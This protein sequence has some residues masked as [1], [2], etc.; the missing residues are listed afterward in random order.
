M[1]NKLI[2]LC[3]LSSVA[4]SFAGWCDDAAGPNSRGAE[5][6]PSWHVTALPDEGVGLPYDAN[7]CIYWKGAYHLMYIFQDKEGKHCWGHLSSTDLVNW[8][9]HPTALQPNPGDADTGTFSGNAFLD[10]E[11]VPML[12]W[13]GIDAGVC[14]AT[15]QD[16]AL[17]RW[18]K[19]PNNPIVPIPKEGQPAYGVY[20]VWDPYLWLEGDTYYC[21]L[22]GNSLPNGKDTLY[23]CKS[24]DLVT[25][26]AVGPFYE[27][28]DLS[29]TTDGE[30]CSCPDFFK[31]GDKHALLCISHKVGARVYVGRFD[32]EKF[33]PE[34]HV[35]MNWPGGA[36]FAPE[37]LLDGKGRR[38]FWAWVVDPRQMSTQRATGSGFQ[39]MPRVLSLAEAGTVRIDPADELRTLRRAH[40]EEGVV[41]VGADAEVALKNI[42][43]SCAEMAFEID[44][45]GAAEAGVKV[46]CAPD[47]T[48]ETGIW[49][50]AKAKLLKIDMGKSTLRKDVRY[51]NG[52]L[53]GYGN[54]EK[55]LRTTVDAP[56]ELRPGETLNL[57]V[58]VDGPMLE[59]FANGRQCVTQLI[60]PASRESVGVKVAAKG[61]KV[62]VKRAEMWEMA[63]ATFEDKRW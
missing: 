40:R 50:D 26:T 21:L 1:K 4:I 8:T 55:N 46:Y 20:K 48:E 52:P 25:W 5:W 34:Q 14:V 35:R 57:R 37:S 30:D 15:S 24:P 28:P 18:Q 36:F 16:D 42:R 3:L 32:G 41:E 58:F 12:C 44:P 9:Y 10:K 47:G 49:Y 6:W 43:G 59:V 45:G 2:L 62:V 53:D 29:W 56:F 63:P 7:G 19:H 22:G 31:L 38:V 61:G 27:H 17:I 13:F 33:Y 51:G 23:L 54:N 39:S 11:G 60:Y